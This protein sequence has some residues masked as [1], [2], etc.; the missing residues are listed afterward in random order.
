MADIVKLER[1]ERPSITEIILALPGKSPEEVHRI[2][3]AVHP[4]AES[5]DVLEAMREADSIVRDFGDKLLRGD[6]VAQ[7]AIVDRT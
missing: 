4:R 2:I 6:Y 1:E 7:H 3:A 5:D